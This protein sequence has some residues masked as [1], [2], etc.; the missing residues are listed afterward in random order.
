MNH[1]RTLAAKK[2]CNIIIIINNNV[3]VRYEFLYCNWH[4]TSVFLWSAG[5][6]SH[7]VALYKLVGYA[8]KSKQKMYSMANSKTRINAK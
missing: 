1:N 6:S 4:I 3:K 7:A 5:A 8:Q 2:K